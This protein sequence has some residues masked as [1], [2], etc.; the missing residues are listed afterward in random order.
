MRLS[1]TGSR[2]FAAWP[3]WRAGFDPVSASL[4]AG[5]LLSAFGFLATIAAVYGLA[6]LGGSPPRAGYWAA[7]LVA[8]TPVHGG[9]PL[10]VRPDVLGI[11]LQTTGILLVLSALNSQ[12]RPK[13]NWLAAFVCFGAAVVHQAAFR[14]GPV[15]QF[16]ITHSGLDSRADRRHVDRALCFDHMSRSSYS[17]T[18]WRNGLRRAE[19]P[20]RFWLPPRT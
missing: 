1:I 19:C 9:L 11:G 13:A 20:G 12:P 10:E 18:V 8:A 6:R 14:D 5:R 15:D 17:A 2:A 7:L 4:I 3:L 16:R